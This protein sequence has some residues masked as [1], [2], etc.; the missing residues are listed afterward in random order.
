[1][2]WSNMRCQTW[3]EDEIEEDEMEENETAA[4]ACESRDVYCTVSLVLTSV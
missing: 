1:M 3:E 2:S 4:A